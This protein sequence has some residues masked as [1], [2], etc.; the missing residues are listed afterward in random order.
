MVFWT[1]AQQYLPVFAQ[2]P[3]LRSRV[4]RVYAPDSPL[5]SLASPRPTEQADLL[6]VIVL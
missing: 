6:Y 2:R 1:L 5:C 3:V 4:P